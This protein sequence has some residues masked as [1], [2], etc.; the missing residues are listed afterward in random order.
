MCVGFYTSRN[1]SFDR[2]EELLSRR[3]ISEPSGSVYPFS[4]ESVVSIENFS[5]LH[6]TARRQFENTHPAAFPHFGLKIGSSAA[7]D[8]FCLM[9]LRCAVPVSHRPVSGCLAAYAT[10]FVCT[11]PAEAD[12]RFKAPLTPR[13]VRPCAALNVF[14]EESCIRGPPPVCIYFSVPVCPAYRR[15]ALRVS[16]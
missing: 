13:S 11:T 3:D 1:K 12:C 15:S 10:L 14:R 9:L 4:I 6:K 16:L 7:H 5:V 8:G 2:R